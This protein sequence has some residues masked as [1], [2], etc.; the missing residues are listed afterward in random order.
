MISRRGFFASA[1]PFMLKGGEKVLSLKEASKLTSSVVIKLD[2]KWIA[3]A[4]LPSI[5]KYTKARGPA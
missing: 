4:I 3:R 2:S 5:S 1:A